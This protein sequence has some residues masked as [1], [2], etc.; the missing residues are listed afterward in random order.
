MHL[1]MGITCNL[2]LVVFFL[3]QPGIYVLMWTHIQMSRFCN[4][5]FVNCLQDEKCSER[6]LFIWLKSG[7]VIHACVNKGSVV[8][9]YGIKRK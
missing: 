6:D 5:H 8:I 3:Y 9:G 4:L 7:D 1:Q 2:P